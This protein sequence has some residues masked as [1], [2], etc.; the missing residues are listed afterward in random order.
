VAIQGLSNVVTAS[1]SFKGSFNGTKNIY[2]AAATATLH[3]GWVQKG[4]FTVSTGG[5]PVAN[6]VS[7]S[8]GGGSSGT[9]TF[10]VSDAGGSSFINGIAVLISTSPTATNNACYLHYDRAANTV[11]LSYNTAANGKAPV[12]LGSSMTTSNSQC[13]LRGTGSSVVIGETTVALTLNLSF[14]GAFGGLK[15]VYLYAAEIGANTGRFS[16]VHG[17]S[18]AGRRQPIR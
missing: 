10:T 17:T 6:G 11:W 3:T 14:F 16:W 7:P 18:S 9:L 5:A 1:V 2:M 13:T 4:A 15:N 12:V 8:P